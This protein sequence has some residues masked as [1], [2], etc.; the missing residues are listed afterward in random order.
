M[1]EGGYCL[2]RGLISSSSEDEDKQTPTDVGL[3]PSRSVPTPPST[4]VHQ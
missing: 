2:L 3:G 4:A 1:E